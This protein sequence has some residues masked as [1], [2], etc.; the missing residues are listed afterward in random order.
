PPLAEGC[1]AVFHGPPVARA[2]WFLRVA[3]MRPLPF[4]LACWA[5]AASTT[6]LAADPLPALPELPTWST[7]LDASLAAGYRDNLL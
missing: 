2:P 1:L 3:L 5:L 4:R 7:T 6:V